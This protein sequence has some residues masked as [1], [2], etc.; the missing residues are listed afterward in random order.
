M[1]GR[2]ITPQHSAYT[3]LSSDRP[4]APGDEV[5]R[6]LNTIQHRHN[7]VNTCVPCVLHLVAGREILEE[8]VVSGKPKV[9]LARRGKVDAERLLRIR[10]AVETRIATAF[11]RESLR[12]SAQ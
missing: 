4:S 7:G 3:S 11:R 12:E 5:L 9:V 6:T 10:E 8:I 2:H 1:T